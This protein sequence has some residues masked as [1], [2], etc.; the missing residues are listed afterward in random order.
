MVPYN[1]KLWQ[2]DLRDISLDWVNWSIPKPNVEDVINGALGIKNKQ[3]GYNPVFYYPKKG[4]IG[5]F[6]NGIPVNGE[7][8]SIARS[9]KSIS[10]RSELLFAM[11]RKSDT[12]IYCQR[13]PCIS[14]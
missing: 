14:S 10:K 4:G 3:F 5:I 9:K 11:A 2:H 1:Q 7:L 8:L 6:P 13:C 12:G